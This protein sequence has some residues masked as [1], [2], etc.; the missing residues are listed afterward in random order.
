[1]PEF[2]SIRSDFRI[3]ASLL[4]GLGS[5]QE[6]I[7]QAPRRLDVPV[8]A[9]S[10]YGKSLTKVISHVQL[11]IGKEEGESLPKIP[12]EVVEALGTVCPLLQWLAIDIN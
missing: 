1:M 4:S 7:L 11:P 12:L 2:L 6:L 8:W 3:R 10:E 9:L 5:L